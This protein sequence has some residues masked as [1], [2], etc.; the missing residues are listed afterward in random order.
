M[1]LIQLKCPSCGSKLDVNPE[2]D[3]YTC[4]YCGV[5]TVLDDESVTIKNVS[6]KLQNHIMDIKEYFEN[7]NYKKSY[8]L[9]KQLLE[10]Y[11]KNKELK[12][13]FEKS[14]EEL[15]GEERR[16][17]EKIEEERK[18]KLAE[19]EAA[20]KEAEEK[21]L[22][23]IKER[24]ERANARAQKISNTIESGLST[25]AVVVGTVATGVGVL[26]FKI[27]NIVLYFLGVCIVIA[28]PFVVGS[29]ITKIFSALFGLSLFKCFYK[30]ID[31]DR[32]KII[33]IRVFVPF[34]IMIFMGI[35]VAV[36][37]KNDNKTPDTTTTTTVSIV[38]E[39]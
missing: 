31:G 26:A 36:D 33:M 12:Y 22:Q 5:T 35:S 37:S 9:S 32:F 25:G 15:F 24:K 11:P 10:E 30:K 2:L 23:E 21:R 18:K 38:N 8:A 6:S 14:D 13:Y 16:R 39:L 20:R 3:K 1:K 7:G 28:S 19:E 17:Q 4:N 27:I 34:W 29:I